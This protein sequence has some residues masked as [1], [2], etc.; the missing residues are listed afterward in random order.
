V[1]A[2]ESSC[3]D[4]DVIVKRITLGEYCYEASVTECTETEETV[5]NEICTY[6][7]EKQYEDTNAQTVEVTFRQESNT[8]M[9]TVCQP[10]YHGYGGYGQKYCK[11]VAQE[12]KY[13]VPVVS[14]KDV[15]VRVGFPVAQKNCINKP[16]TIPRISCETRT[17]QKCVDQP[18]IEETTETLEKCETSL[19]EPDCQKIELTLPKQVCKELVYGYAE[20]KAPKYPQPTYKPEPSYPQPSSYPQPQPSYPKP[21]PTYPPSTTTTAKA[22]YPP[23][24]PP[25]K[26]S[27]YPPPPPPSR[28]PPAPHSA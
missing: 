2:V 12:T 3:E 7:Y 13:N 26:P 22:R 19:A 4:V 25:P 21:Q 23:P 27:S 9:V 8:Q 17:E 6:N 11:E 18:E 28:Y 24:P 5:D 1:P 20:D 16:I 15:P 10:G 14:P